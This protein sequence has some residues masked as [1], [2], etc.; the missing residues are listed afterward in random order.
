MSTQESE[1]DGGGTL[2]RFRAVAI[3]VTVGLITFLTPAAPMALAAE[4]Q[5]FIAEVSTID[6]SI[7]AGARAVFR[8]PYSCSTLVDFCTGARIDAPIPVGAAPESGQ[9]VVN[10][11]VAS[12]TSGDVVSINLAPI[13]GGTSGELQVSWLIP[14]L[15]TLPNTSIVQTITYGSDGQAD[16]SETSGATVVTAAASITAN[17]V[18]QDPTDETAVVVDRPVTYLIYDC[19]PGL[20]A[21]GG[22]GFSDVTLALTLPPGVQVESIGNGGSVAGN[23]ATWRTSAPSANS[24]D[25]PT[26]T[27]SITVRYPSAVFEPAP[28]SPPAV[29]NHEASLQVTATGL[30]GSALSGTDSVQH[31]FVGDSSNNSYGT[32]T[33]FRGTSGGDWAAP[34]AISRTNTSAI[35]DWRIYGYWYMAAIGLKPWPDRYNVI[36]NTS[37]IPCVTATAAVSPA[38]RGSDPLVGNV[39]GD[40]SVPANQCH[41]PA[42]ETRWIALDNYTASKIVQFEA[43]TWDGTVGKVYKWNP[44]AAAAGP[45]QIAVHAPTDIVDAPRPA[46]PTPAIEG[47]SSDG[48]LITQTGISVG[49]SAGTPTVYSLGVPAGEIVT[50]VRVVYDQVDYYN[51]VSAD[52]YGSSTQAFADS[53]FSQ[54]SNAI[55]AMTYAGGFPWGSPATGQWFGGNDSFQYPRTFTQP[56]PD[57]VVTVTADD[58]V[59]ALAPRDTP[60]WRAVMTN[61]LN[62]TPLNPRMAVVIPAGQ[63]LVEGSV[64]WSNLGMLDGA[65]PSVTT[66]TIVVDGEP[67]TELIFT[68]D[69]SHVIDNPADTASP[70]H[71]FFTRGELPTVTFRTQVA[72][73]VRDGTRT[74]N[75][76][77]LVYLF[78]GT[79]DLAPSVGAEADQFDADADGVTAERVA[80]ASESWTAVGS[81]AVTAQIFTRV[82]PADEWTKGAFIDDVGRAAAAPIDYRILVENRQ[83]Y[84]VGDFVMYDVFPHPGDHPLTPELRDQRRAS[85]WTPV[86]VGMTTVPSFVEVSYSTS[87]EPCRPELFD[88]DQGP[89][90]DDWTNTMPPPA[91]VTALRMKVSEPYEAP[92]ADNPPLA[93]EYSMTAPPSGPSPLA[94]TIAAPAL[95]APAIADPALLGSTPVAPGTSPADTTI[96]WRATRVSGAGQVFPLPRAESAI[97]RVSLVTGSIEGVAWRD[98]D[99]SGVLDG[100]EPAIADV[101]VKLLAADRTPVLDDSGNPVTTTTDAAGHYSFT[102]P[103]GFYTVAFPTSSDG[104]S[105]TTRRV[106]VATGSKPAADGVTSPLGVSGELAVVTNVNAGYVSS[107]PTTAEGSGAG[108]AGTGSDAISWVPVAVAVLLLGLLLLARRRGASSR[109][110]ARRAVRAASP[111]APPD[112]M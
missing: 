17:L 94:L 111:P 96:A 83:N 92:D 65:E 72:Q 51:M 59:S 28:A 87:L 74:G 39:P 25:E 110:G 16:A 95:A 64:G 79:T 8:L 58:P 2:R 99:G 106:D 66:A 103:F 32:T 109:P 52:M 46:G 101:P 73:A 43:V 86:F 11:D 56:A 21:L 41:A 107:H 112:A 102:V 22:L 68:W 15:T 90:D 57:P 98:I 27:Y 55:A 80:I 60:Q 20:T 75:E 97:A 82:D 23:V 12:V 69:P 54:M 44:P 105:L 40:W 104:E 7:Q 77:M 70:D 61:G 38:P 9:A 89:C 93:I 50:D 33:I 81:A 84:R 45:I 108:L 78:D 63:T 100:G 31:T 26:R 1:K 53:G 85:E 6:P 47:E 76:A 30:D 13:P 24:C 34:R 3:A 49:A 42:F 91:S 48:G 14:N 36:V 71:A 37:R 35:Y 19:N 10:A 5:A 29:V 18:M 88:G 67:R 62:G 4:G